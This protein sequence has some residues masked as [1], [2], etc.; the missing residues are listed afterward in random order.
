MSASSYT[1]TY[2]PSNAND[3]DQSTYWESA[4]NAFPQWLQ[5]DLG[6]TTSVNQLVLQ[7]PVANW[8][9]R[10][11]TLSVQG[12]TDG[13]NFT[14]IVASAPYTFDPGTN[15]TVTI[16]FAATGTRYLRALVTANTGWPA[17]QVSGFQV[18][19]PSTTDTTPPTAPGTLSYTQPQAGRIALSWG[20]ST[21]NVGVTAYDVYRNGA[22]AGTVGGTT[23]T[24]TDNQPG[25][26]T[27]SYYVKARDAAGNVSPAGNTVTRD[28]TGGTGTNL[29]LHKPITGTPYTY[30]YAPANAND[31]DP[32]TYF[33]GSSYPSR[34]TVQLGANADV[35]SVVVKLNPASAWST[36]TQT[37][38]VLGREQSAT[39]FTGISAAQTY[40]FDPSTGNTVTIPVSARVADVELSITSNSGAP[41]GQ[42]GELQVI[43]TPAPNPD[44]TVSASSWSPS[45]PVET[46]SVTASAT[47]ANVGT[48]AAPASDVNFYLGSTKVGTAP[49]GA[50]AAGASTKVSAVIG[51]Q[52]AG[53]YQLT[54][55]VDEAKSF[56]ELGYDNN[57]FTNPDNLVV[58]PV[59]SSDLVGTVD[60]TPN[61]PSAGN[62]VTFSVTLKNQGTLASGSGS[63]GVTLTLLDSTGKTL[64]TLTGSYTGTIA[65]GASAPP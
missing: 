25:T 38:Q 12:S 29:A 28:G 58:A 4:N 46:D 13:S 57:A 63:H 10:T 23:L 51:T 54:A 26:A 48:A 64:T 43:G 11:Q 56:I 40:T 22:L 31:G 50:L 9:A 49:V 59:Q 34:L 7:V 5:V 55:K 45:A 61:N 32:T 33:E 60:W 15:S 53:T 8:P 42:V 24:W 65:A 19:G 30:I 52:T 44:L 16:N 21:D 35:T 36:R 47:V 62:N 17:A 20:A 1:Q 27:V 37:I 41:G 39:D 3:G 6:A 18:Y 14:T 2:T